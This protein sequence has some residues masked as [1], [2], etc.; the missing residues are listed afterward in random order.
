MHIRQRRYESVMSTTSIIITTSTSIRRTYP[1]FSNGRPCAVD[2]SG[3]YL[4]EAHVVCRRVIVSIHV[5]VYV[6]VGVGTQG[7]TAKQAQLVT[8]V[9]E[10]IQFIQ[11]PV[12]SLCTKHQKLTRL[13]A[14]RG[15]QNDGDNEH[16]MRCWTLPFLESTCRCWVQ[17]KCLE[18]PAAA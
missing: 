4:C 5:F 17:R 15:P 11:F 3:A 13:E 9:G 2:K 10:F 16:H 8:N 18:T 12:C 6:N 1:S 7:Q 14:P